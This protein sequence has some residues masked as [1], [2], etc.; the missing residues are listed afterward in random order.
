MAL[1][2]TWVISQYLNMDPDIQLLRRLHGAHVCAGLCPALNQ[3]LLSCCSWDSQL[4][5]FTFRDMFLSIS[6]RLP[7]QYLYGFGETEHTTFRRNI[8]WHTWGMFARDE[9]PAVSRD[10]IINISTVYKFS[11]IPVYFALKWN[12]PCLRFSFLSV[13][14]LPI[15]IYFLWTMDFIYF[16]NFYLIYSTCQ[17]HVEWDSVLLRYCLFL[18][19]LIN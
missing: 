10:K 17:A 14:K 6:T 1:V 8:S 18:Q 2:M 16:T 19:M 12:T 13:P 9:P 15:Y 7:S 11:L 5:G 4:P 3:G